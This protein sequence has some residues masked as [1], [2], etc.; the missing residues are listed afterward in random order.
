LPVPL[1]TLPGSPARFDDDGD[2]LYARLQR[3]ERLL[4]AF[5]SAQTPAVTASGQAATNLASPRLRPLTDEVKRRVG[6]DEW[7][8]GDALAIRVLLDELAASVRSC[9]V[10]AT[11][12]SAQLRDVHSVLREADRLLTREAARQASEASINDGRERS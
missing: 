6:T 5:S 3:L 2:A 10:V 8:A 9:R 11:T 4:E 12:A 1:D 7:D